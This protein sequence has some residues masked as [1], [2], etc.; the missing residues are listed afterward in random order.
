[1]LMSF[2]M[3]QQLLLILVSPCR[4]TQQAERRGY[5]YLT[6]FISSFVPS[7]RGCYGLWPAHQASHPR[8][9]WRCACITACLQMSV[10]GADDSCRAS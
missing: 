4:T 8:E 3:C 10:A 5:T 9:V 1:M 7:L 2:V 6:Y